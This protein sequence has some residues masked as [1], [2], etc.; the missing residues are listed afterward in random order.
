[1]INGRFAVM[2]AGM[3]AP[4]RCDYVSRYLAKMMHSS[5]K[6]EGCLVYNIHQSETNNNEFMMYSEWRD[7]A[8]FDQHNKTPEMQE[9][10][11][12]LAKDMFDVRSPRTYWHVLADE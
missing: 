4:D 5:R 7:Q 12:E 9:F 6:S 11:D 8:S 1:M 3:V 10:I 2:V